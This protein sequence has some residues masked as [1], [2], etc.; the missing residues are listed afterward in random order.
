MLHYARGSK[1]KVNSLTLY[2]STMLTHTRDSEYNVTSRTCDSEYLAHIYVTINCFPHSTAIDCGTAPV[3]TNGQ[4][5]SHPV[6]TTLY[7]STKSYRCNNGYEIS[8]GVTTTQTTCTVL[9]T[10]DPSSLPACSCKFDWFVG[11]LND[12]FC[13]IDHEI[14]ARLIWY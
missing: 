5:N 3:L 6:T 4:E 12:W 9:E 1:Y 2:D 7:G 8:D 14:F 11:D 10:W 13:L